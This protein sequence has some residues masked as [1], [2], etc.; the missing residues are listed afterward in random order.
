MRLREGDPAGAE[1]AAR[2]ALARPGRRDLTIRFER[3]KALIEALLDQGK[4]GEAQTAIDELRGKLGGEDSFFDQLM[5]DT[6]S[7]RLRAASKKKADQQAALATLSAVAKRAGDAGLVYYRIAAEL[8]SAR[9]T[10]AMDPSAGQLA[11]VN[12]MRDA[13]RR[14]LYAIA[15][16]AIRIL[17]QRG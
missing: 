10:L 11:L 8:E 16:T 13:K 14:E 15:E 2:A 4:T 5:L 1:A 3:E 6:L 17:Q 9:I 7:A 12:V